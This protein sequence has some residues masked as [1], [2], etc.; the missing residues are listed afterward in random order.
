MRRLLPIILGGTVLLAAGCGSEGV[1][2]PLPNTVEGT[3]PT[4]PT[5]TGD[6]AKGKAV[7]A[8][9]GCGGCHTFK[10]A[11]TTGTVGPSLDNL[12]ESAKAAGQPLE[13]FVHDSIVNPNGYI[14]KGYQPNVMPGTFQ[15]QFSDQQIADL[16]AFIV[17]NQQ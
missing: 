13:A 7:F 2:Q 17:S 8:S 11:G 15:S 12:S 4:G 14:A 10:A 1:T 3:V 6:P 5:L 16:V 9:G